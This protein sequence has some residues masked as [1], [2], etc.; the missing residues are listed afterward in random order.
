MADAIVA[1]HL[2]L[3]I[4]PEMDAAG[5]GERWLGALQPGALLYVGKPRLSTGGAVA[6]TGLALHQLG[7][8]VAL[9]GKLGDD[10]FGKAVLERVASASGVLAAGMR[11]SPG[12]VTS[13]TLVL[14]PPGMDRIFLHCP[15]ANDCFAADDV[16]GR[17][18]ETARLF[19]LGYP[20]LM[21][22]LYEQDGREL[23]RILAKAK[24]GGCT[25][26]L[27]LA[28][29]DPDSD[30]GRADWQRI[31]SRSLPLVDCFLPSLDELVFIFLRERFAGFDQKRGAGEPLGGLTAS[32][33]EALAD[34]CLAFG[35]GMA[36]IKLGADGLFLKTTS[37]LSRLR[38]CGKLLAPCAAQWAG[39]T[40]YAPCYDVTVA[41]TTGAGDC[42]I[43]G[44]LAALLRGLSPCEALTAGVATGASCVE[45]AD[46]VSGVPGW[47]AL[48]TRIRSGWT[49]H[50]A[51]P[52]FTGGGVIST[53]G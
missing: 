46:A 30:A 43:A 1:G 28:R 32:E 31:L 14:N 12:A 3:D 26:S 10:L 51:C 29:P 37:D 17:E 38:R 33:V 25:V 41:G 4:I 50:A 53:R 13:Y 44:F 45:Q 11:V 9:Q 35:A 48:Q 6:N 22:S 23:E 24:A 19:H 39:V 21:R 40:E 5:A 27:D 47:E 15:G 52:A 36:V 2:C 18:L 20:P 16:D 8:D 42:T 34:R 49:R 7:A